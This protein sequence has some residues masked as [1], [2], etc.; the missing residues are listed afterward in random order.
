[1]KGMPD[2]LF[3]GIVPAIVTPFRADER[4][5]YKAWQE[6]IEA[7]IASGVDG[8]LC[9]GGQG[10]FYALTEEER[11]VAARFATQTADGRVSVYVNVGSNSTQ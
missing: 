6:L 8:L 9:L 1:M 11:E 3:R 2:G 7:L 5:D 10:E 4:I